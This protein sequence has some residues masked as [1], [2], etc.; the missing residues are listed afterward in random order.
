MTVALASPPLPRSLDDGLAHVRRCVTE[1]AQRGAVV[2]CFPEAYLPGL[3]GMGVEVPR[4]TAADQARVLAEGSAVAREASIGV[5]LGMEW[6][7]PEG[8][9]IAAVVFGPTGDMMGVQ[10]KTQLDPTEEAHYVPGTRREMFEIGGLRFGVVICH[11]GFRYP[12]TVRWAA[13]R[14]AQVVFHPHMT[15]GDRTGPDGTNLGLT[16]WADPEAPY[17]EKAVMCRAL[18]NTVYVA[19]VNVGV[20]FPESATAVVDPD[21]ALV[22]RLPY[23]EPG[24]LVVDLDL[25]RATGHLASRYAPERY[26]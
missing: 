14:G 18:E 13:R 21:G 2:V 12:E 17:Y 16:R 19:S 7:A 1:A 23:G 4:F 22:D 25:A 10:A 26:A 3:R 6:I 20:R 11:E 8:H 24:V 15:G 9:Q 5:I